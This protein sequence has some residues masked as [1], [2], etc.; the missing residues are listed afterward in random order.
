MLLPFNFYVVELFPAGIRE[1][2]M[3]CLTEIIKNLLNLILLYVYLSKKS[4]Y[5][6]TQSQSFM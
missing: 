2:A 5:M 1:D 3:F 4:I 6:R